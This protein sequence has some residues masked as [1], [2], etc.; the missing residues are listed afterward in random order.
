MGFVYSVQELWQGKISPEVAE[1]L[2]EI[3]VAMAEPRHMSS[4]ATDQLPKAGKSDLTSVEPRD[5]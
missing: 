4:G 5:E 1:R 2:E 3:R